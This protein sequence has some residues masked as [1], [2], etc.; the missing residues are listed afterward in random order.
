MRWEDK[1]PK[2]GDERKRDVFCLIPRIAKKEWVWL[3]WIRVHQ[4]FVGAG[5]FGGHYLWITTKI[6]VKPYDK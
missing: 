6:E 2:V 4:K 3:E 5:A 1:T